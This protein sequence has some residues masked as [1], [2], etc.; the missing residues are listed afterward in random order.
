[1]RG[2][3]FVEKPEAPCGASLW[4][5]DVGLV[6]PP[7]SRACHRPYISGTPPV[8]VARGRLR[9]ARI[10]RL[11]AGFQLFRQNGSQPLHVGALS[12]QRPL[13]VWVRHAQGHHQRV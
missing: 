9:W 4:L 5:L 12:R 10:D 6:P 7:T 11:S 8:V 3:S 1:M 2:E 13:D